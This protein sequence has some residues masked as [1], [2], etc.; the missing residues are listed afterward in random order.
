VAKE[1]LTVEEIAGPLLLVQEVEGVTYGELAEIQ[2]SDGV[3]RRGRV[4]DI[5]QD[6]ALVQVFEGTAG[7]K[8]EQTKVKF[9]GRGQEIGVS[10]EMLGRIFDGSGRPIDDGPELIPEKRLNINGASRP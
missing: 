8:T 10:P 9:L 4:L 3:V 7:I 6:K 5:D 1:Y 2:L